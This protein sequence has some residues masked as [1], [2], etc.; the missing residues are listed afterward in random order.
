MKIKSWLIFKNVFG[1]LLSFFF[2]KNND[3]RLNIYQL[4]GFILC[5]YGANLP[6]I[7]C[8]RKSEISGICLDNEKDF[9]EIIFFFFVN[10]YFLDYIKIQ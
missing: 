2:E 9:V 4:C 7:G 8:G 6:C 1:M 10:Y 3:L 5:T